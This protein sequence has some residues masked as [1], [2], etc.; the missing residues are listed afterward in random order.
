MA[1]RKAERRPK[2]AAAKPAPAKAPKARPSRKAKAAPV[3][4][5]GARAT[6]RRAA[7]ARSNPT[8]ALEIFEAL[9]KRHADAHCEL[10]HGSAFE[11]IVATVLSAQSTDVTVNQVTPELF[12]R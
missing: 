5:T 1:S 7:R 6:P 4:T 2:P 10:V 8:Q 3:R 12:R 9:R 11:L